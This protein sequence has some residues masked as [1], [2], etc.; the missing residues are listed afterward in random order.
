MHCLSRDRWRRGRGRGG[1]RGRAGGVRGGADEAHCD[2]DDREWTYRFLSNVHS[3]QVLANC[4]DRGKHPLESMRALSLTRDMA[5]FIETPPKAEDAVKTHVESY[6]E[7]G[8]KI[9][10]AW[11]RRLR[12]MDAL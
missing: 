6:V 4:A 1:A 3:E 11:E 5:D 2:G 9:T 8:L 7:M 10:D 12:D